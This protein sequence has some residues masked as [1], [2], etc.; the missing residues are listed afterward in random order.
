VFRLLEQAAERRLDEQKADSQ[1]SRGRKRAA[2]DTVSPVS[3]K[4]VRATTCVCLLVVAQPSQLMLLSSLQRRLFEDAAAG[5]LT[6]ARFESQLKAAIDADHTHGAV[7]HA[8]ALGKSLQD[9]VCCAPSPR[10]Y[11]PPFPSQ[12]RVLHRPSSFRP[13]SHALHDCRSRQ[14][15]MRCV[16]FDGCVRA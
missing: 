11:S 7:E 9:V 16:A 6:P 1:R 8:K 2:S 10:T 12:A 3:D 13:W 4:H 14:F 5:T 15:I